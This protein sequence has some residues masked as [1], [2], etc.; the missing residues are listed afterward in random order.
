M[1]EQC[2]VRPDEL[3]LQHWTVH[4]LTVVYVYVAV[5]ASPFWGCH[6]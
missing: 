6:G 4:S 2:V 3:T 1:R 5:F